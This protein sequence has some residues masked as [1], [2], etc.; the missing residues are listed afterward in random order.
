MLQRVGCWLS[1]FT[2]ELFRLIQSCESVSRFTKRSLVNQ[3]T[4][5]AQNL[6]VFWRRDAS[7]YIQFTLQ[8]HVHNMSKIIHLS[9]HLITIYH[10]SPYPTSPYFPASCK[11]SV[12]SHKCVYN[13]EIYREKVINWVFPLTL[14][15]A[16]SVLGMLMMEEKGVERATASSAIS[17][18][19][20]RERERL[21]FTGPWN[22]RALP[23]NQHNKREDYFQGCFSWLWRDDP[24]LRLRG[25]EI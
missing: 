20:W 22:E 19:F 6:F 9:S 12:S 5:L 24:T 8:T 21:R 17:S 10:K 14:P 23:Q 15:H 25:D 1:S 7:L 13:S 16:R 4:L 11:T 18:A 3:S 2:K